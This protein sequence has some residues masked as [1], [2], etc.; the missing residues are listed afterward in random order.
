GGDGGGEFDRLPPP[1]LPPGQ[2]ASHSRRNHR[3]V[4]E[5]SVQ[6]VPD[7]AFISPDE[8][9]ERS[10]FRIA[11]GAFISPDEPLPDRSEMLDSAVERMV[12]GMG[13]DAHL[14]EE[15]LAVSRHGDPSVTDLVLKVGRLAEQLRDKGEAGLR[16]TPDMTRFEATLR[17]YCVGY[18]AG[19]R[20]IK[21]D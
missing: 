13:D 2:R 17:V 15:D 5:A 21:P 4:Q 3:P 6:G 10:G 12:T 11:E 14:G 16:T 18:L 19:Q 9:I 7:E 20:E 1:A 8:P